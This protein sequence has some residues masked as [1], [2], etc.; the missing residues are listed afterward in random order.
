MSV[1][2]KNWTIG[3]L[4]FL[5][6]IGLL[7]GF[8]PISNRLLREVNG[9]FSLSPYSSLSLIH[10][11]NVSRGTSVGTPIADSL[12]N[13]TGRTTTFVRTATENHTVIGDG[14]RKLRNGQTLAINVRTRGARAGEMRIAINHSKIYTTVPL[15]HGAS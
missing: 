2:S 14:S 1:T 5:V 6:V 8:T 13:H 9:S 10:P 11:A 4:L 15:V 7:I 12:S 3:A